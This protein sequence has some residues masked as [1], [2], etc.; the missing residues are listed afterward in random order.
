MRVRAVDIFCGAGGLTFGLEKAGINVVLGVDTDPA[1]AYPYSHNTGA[2]F[3]Q[4]DVTDLTAETLA[5]YYGKCKYK[6]LVGCA[7]CQPFST[8]TQGLKIRDSRWSLLRIFLKLAL[9]L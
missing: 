4:K 2:K 8:Y 3:L 1:C 5:K 7:P 9:K 6:I